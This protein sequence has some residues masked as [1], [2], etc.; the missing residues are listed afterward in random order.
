MKITSKT[1]GQA[2]DGQSV[3][4]FV[5]SNDRITIKIT[6]YGGIITSIET[7]DK[8]G[9][10]ANIACGFD[11][12]SDYL[13]P[14][15]LGNYPYFGCLLGRY[16]NR[17][18]KGR[19]TINGKEYSG[20]INNGQNHLHGGTGFD[21]KVW[22]PEVIEKPDTVSI[23]LTYVSPDM[24]EGYPGTL[25]VCCIYTLD[26]DNCLTISFEATTDKTTILN[27]ANHTYFNLTGGKENIFDHELELKASRYTESSDLIPT[28]N[29]LP[30]AGTPLDFTKKK[31]IRQDIASLPEGYDLNFVL[32]KQDGI[33]PEAAVL[34]EE[35]SGRTIKVCTT[36][37]GLQVY[38]GYW[39]PELIINGKK[40]FG[41]YSGIAL[42]TQHYPDSPNHPEF[43]TT[44]LNPG[45]IFK[46][47]TS[48]R[49][50]LL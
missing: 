41:R 10:I 28:G 11:N 39:I 13:S 15:Y 44:L 9:K 20:V 8:E 45:E 29:I 24:E 34:S 6:N 19:Y 46:Q 47:T 48:F 30:V 22:V 27:L 26:N 36:Q 33:L 25:K 23:K 2:T 18:A 38:T 49:F 7:P 14:S 50:G 32:D 31:K 37:P 17:I 12:L 4:L 5:L 35:T 21:R 43:P 3:E 1:F 42:E 16:A 40:K